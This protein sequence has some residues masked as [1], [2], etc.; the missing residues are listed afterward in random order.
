MSASEA[1]VDSDVLS[2]RVDALIE[3]GRTGAARPLLA[4]IRKVAPPSARIAG[5]SARLAM[6]E[7]RMHDAV[8]DLDAALSLSPGDAG[9][10]KL[11]AEARAQTGDPEGAASDAAEAVHLDPA[12]PVAKAL[13]G[14]ALLGLGRTGESAVCLAEALRQQPENPSFC[15]GL[16]VALEA[17]GDAMGA[18]ATLQAGIAAAPRSADLRSAAIQQRMRHR[19]FAGAHALAVAARA[20]GAIDACVLGLEGHALSSLGRGEEAA[21]VYRDALRLAPDDPY[22]RHLVAASGLLPS[23]ERAPPAYLRAVFDGYAS[24]FEHHL[25]GLGYRVPGLLRAALLDHLPGLAGG[26]PAGPVLDLGCGT[27]LLAL[28]AMDLPLGPWTGVDLSGRMLDEARAKALYAELREA[29]LLDALAA[30]SA[31]WP[32]ILAGDVLC[33]F[34][35]LQTAFERVV[36]RL[37]PGGIFLFSVEE[38]AA[39]DDGRGASSPGWTIGVQGRYAHDQAYVAT[40]ARG[41]GLTVCS[42][43]RETLRHEAGAPVPGLLVVLS[44]PR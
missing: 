4:A 34:G 13:L 22:V 9:L 17:G 30:D 28:V 11:R 41:A 19:D 39:A 27:G 26:R 6:R 12:D 24:R 44:R 37:A 3:A 5:L 16:A 15:R 21:E 7:E 40:A 1:V 25:L 10:H 29:D 35:A 42:V 2:R 20:V 43:R 38:R 23:A 18:E 14:M 31:E 32:V 8:G 36:A 33:Y